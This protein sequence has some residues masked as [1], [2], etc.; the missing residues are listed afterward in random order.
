MQHLQSCDMLCH[1]PAYLYL[2]RDTINQWICR[3]S[4]SYRRKHLISLSHGSVPCVYHLLGVGSVKPPGCSS[5]FNRLESLILSFIKLAQAGSVIIHQVHIQQGRNTDKA[6]NI[7]RKHVTKSK[8]LQFDN[9]CWLIEATEWVC[10]FIWIEAIPRFRD[11]PGIDVILLK[12]EHFLS[13]T[14]LLHRVLGLRQTGYSWDVMW[15]SKKILW[16]LPWVNGNCHLT[17]DRTTSKARCNGLI[18]LS[19]PHGLCMAP[20]VRIVT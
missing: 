17:V 8:T 18:V 4:R 1:L 16:G 15:L 3:L 10:S 9:S 7:E 13:S 19:R 12:K 11:I 14:V 20:A 6:W 2:T 5:F